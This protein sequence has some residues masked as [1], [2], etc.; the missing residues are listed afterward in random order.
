MEKSKL[1]D[2]KSNLNLNLN[3]ILKLNNFHENKY[4]ENSSDPKIFPIDISN[5]RLKEIESKI[6]LPN[7]NKKNESKNFNLNEINENNIRNQFNFKQNP[8][9][10]SNEVLINQNLFLDQNMR[11]SKDYLNL[12]KNEIRYKRFDDFENMKNMKSGPPIDSANFSKNTILNNS[13]NTMYKNILDYLSYNNQMMQNIQKLLLSNNAILNNPIESVEKSDNYF[14]E[15]SNNLKSNFMSS[16]F[17]IYNKI[18]NIND[19]YDKFKYQ[20]NFE[21]NLKLEDTF[22]NKPL[23]TNPILNENKFTNSLKTKDQINNKQLQKDLFEYLNAKSFENINENETDVGTSLYQNDI[24][25]NPFN[26]I[27]ENSSLSNINYS[28]Q[29]LDKNAYLNN[30][31]N[32]FNVDLLSRFLNIN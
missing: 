26:K 12:N 31:N 9:K 5:Y 7:N 27:I 6:S 1:E 22:K 30:N 4:L 18:N 14:L 13:Q 25:N 29:N 10:N 21:N 24:I 16:P 8:L 3:K 23:F 28:N 11:N 15:N 20:N 19:G 17:T 32:N 2:F